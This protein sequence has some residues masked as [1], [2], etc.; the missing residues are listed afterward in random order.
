MKRRDGFDILAP[1]YDWVFRPPRRTPL[2]GIL[3]LPTGGRLLDVGG[4]TGRHAQQ[5][6]GRAALVVVADAS[7]PMLRRARAKPGLWPVACLAE[8]LPFANSAFDRVV[9]VDAYHHLID[10]EAS[11]AE[12]WRVLAPK[13]KL[14]IEEPDIQR[15]AVRWVA[16]ME[17]WAGMRSYFIPAEVIAARLARLG[18]MA[19]V[20]R[21]GHAAWIVADRPSAHL[22][23]HQSIQDG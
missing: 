21:Q 1:I 11:L 16:R 9:M 17:R 23:A 12:L 8:R 3:G 14:V 15:A 10:Q 19:S 6:V 5:W 18:G 22:P 20:R 13:G 7:G 4:G 2:G